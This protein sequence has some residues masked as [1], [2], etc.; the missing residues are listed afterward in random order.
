MSTDYF[1]KSM[2]WPG[3]VLLK[4]PANTDTTA[5]QLRDM[6]VCD[7]ILGYF[8]ISNDLLKVCWLLG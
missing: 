1:V 5:S 4:R 6:C 2:R 7:L 8:H 3:L